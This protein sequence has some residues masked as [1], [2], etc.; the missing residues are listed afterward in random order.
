MVEFGGLQHWS[1]GKVE[2]LV[3]YVKGNFIQGRTFTNLVS[4]HENQPKRTADKILDFFL[5][6]KRVLAKYTKEEKQKAIDLYIRYC[7]QATLVLRNLG[8]LTSGTHWSAET[9]DMKRK[10]K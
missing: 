3:R 4:D 1:K 2:R 9:G 10:V 8:I 6:R 5:R 7:R